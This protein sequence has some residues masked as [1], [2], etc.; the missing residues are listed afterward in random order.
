MASPPRSAPFS[1]RD[2]PPDDLSRRARETRERILDAAG[3]LL[4]EHG[5]ART[6]VEGVAAAAGVSKALVYHHFRGKRSILDAVV[7]RTLAGWEETCLREGWPGDGDALRAL[8]ALQRSGI[9]YARENP[10]LRALF[11]LDPRILAGLSRSATLRR[12]LERLRGQL[13]EVLR[14]GVAQG[15]LRPDLDVERTADVV[16]LLHLA[17]LDHLF[18]DVWTPGFEDGLVE[19]SLDVLFRGIAAGGSA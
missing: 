19:A 7:E 3:R 15:Q 18:E 17:L 16:G 6:T 1:A 12:A 2:L 11:Q 5:W 14:A 9:R 13:V 8:E 10:L 4:A